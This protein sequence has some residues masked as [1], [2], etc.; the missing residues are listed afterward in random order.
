[1]DP[2]DHDLERG[3][4][5]R[6][7]ILGDAWV[8][9]S[10]ANAN[11]FTADF[12]NFIT[13]YAWHEAWGRPGLSAKTRRI[14]VL[15][16]TCALGRW[17]EFELHLLAALKGGSGASLGAGDDAATA[18]TP[19]EVKEVLIQAAIYAGVPA[20]NTGMAIAVKLL[21]ELGHELPPLPAGEVAHTGTGRSFKTA[22]SRS[23][24]PALHYTVREPRNGPARQT[25]VF[26]H[27]LGCDVS[28]WDA[29]A[30]TLA[31]DHRV[32]CYEHRG[33]GDS[34]VPA[35]PYTMA[36]L[37]DDA[38]RLIETLQCG[39]V[40][41]VG[42]SL[43]GMVGQEMALNHPGQI[44]AL[45]IANTTSGYDAAARAGWAQRIAAIEA[46][47]LEAIADGAMQRWFSTAF[48][49][50]HPAVVAR[51]R[52]RVV[53]QPAAGYLAAS[54]AVMNHDTTARLPQIRRPTLVIAGSAD[55]GTPVAMSQALAQGIAGAE[56]VVLDG[57]AHLS[58]LEQP[59]AFTAAL[60]AFIAKLD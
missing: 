50:A 18:L 14:V 40:V 3:L 1:M 58:A 2:Y 59:A 42:L 60:A 52:R 41:W 10:I 27:A 8:D 57:A 20:A 11:A 24:V 26:G 23:D 56:L 54:H 47:G 39:P 6:R 25:I 5:N 44:K 45:V 46:G 30:N 36:A 13:R 22:P 16:I 7:A 48:R 4:R 49:E 9:Q 12:Q 53:T 31:A 51:W 33:H 35:G 34:D 55:E 19:D 21:R 15:A 29:V 17:E 32:V 43:G 28:M 38:S 37:A